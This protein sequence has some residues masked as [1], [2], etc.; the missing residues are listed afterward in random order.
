MM[1][2]LALLVL[3]LGALSASPPS[4]AED[5]CSAANTNPGEV[6]A[7]GDVRELGRESLDDAAAA[8]AA[9]RKPISRVSV[10]GEGLASGAK[11]IGGADRENVPRG[12]SY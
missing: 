2:E 1:R 10:P 11:P 3:V 7:C 8:A 4:R 6:V 5:G 12:R 9:P